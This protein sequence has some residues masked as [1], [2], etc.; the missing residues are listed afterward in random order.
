M[1]AFPN[2]GFD[3]T[4]VPGITIG[5][6]KGEGPGGSRTID[7]GHNERERN[8]DSKGNGNIIGDMMASGVS[9]I[10]D[11]RNEGRE[12]AE[13]RENIEGK[14]RKAQEIALCIWSA[15]ARNYNG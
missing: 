6:G 7:L 13:G 9:K 10:D 4:G 11:R 15:T 2:D 12:S 5:I 8:L 1:N 3:R 14:M